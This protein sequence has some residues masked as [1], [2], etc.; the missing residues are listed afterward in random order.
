MTDSELLEIDGVGKTTVEKLESAGM[1]T[2]M[3][4]A[5]SSPADIASLCG[6]SEAKARTII[7]ECRS[8]LQLGF[9]QAKIHAKKREIITRLSTGCKE[10]DRVLGGGFESGAITEIY[11]RTG[12]GKT[13]LTHTLAVRAI[14]ENETN[15]AIIIDS[16]S[17]FRASR[18]KD[19]SEFYK[20]DYDNVM[21]RIYIARSFNHSHQILLVDELEKI[22]Q[23]DN[24]YRLLIID[25]LT[26]HFRADFSGRGELANRQQLLNKHLHQLL[27][28]ADVYNLVVICTNQVQ[29]DP[30]NAYGNPE[31]PIGGNIL[32]HSATSILYIRPAA[33]GT[34]SAEL[35]DSPD[36]PKEKCLYMITKNGI[37]DL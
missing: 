3:A 15:K 27:K 34:W 30:G 12:S 2:L 16:E 6:M 5:V 14:L 33:K 18:I 21:E 25:S 23:K 22:L 10:L 35:V 4:V 7:K 28:I 32:S 1:G 36:L 9:E 24:T 20:L 17:T 29:S 11:G 13:Q 26:S 37:E 8:K 19:I 31:K